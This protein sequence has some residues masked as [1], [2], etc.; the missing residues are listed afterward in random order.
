MCLFVL[1][2]SQGSGDAA[3]AATDAAAPG[4]EHEGGHAGPVM[5]VLLALVIMLAGAK[6]AGY[7]FQ[8]LHQP[9]VLGEL[10]FGVLIGNLALFGFHG[11]DF[12]MTNQGILILAEIGVILLLFE[13]GLDSNLDEMRSVGGSSLFVAVLGVVAPFFLGWGLS[14][15]FLPDLD[16]MVHIFIGAT[17][18]ATSVGITARVLAD[19]RK[20]DTQEARII[21]GA[22]VLDD[23]LGLVVLAIVQGMILASSTGES[24]HALSIVFIVF[25]AIAF[26][27][28][29]VIIGGKVPDV[30][31]RIATRLNMQGILLPFSLG[32]CFLLSYL[33]SLLDLA[34][35]VGAFAAGLILD[36][37]RF[38]DKLNPVDNPDDL[39]HD[40]TLED[41][42]LPINSFLV[43]VFFVLMGTRVDLSTFGQVEV[44]GFALALS[45][46]AVVGKMICGLGVFG[47]DVWIDRLSVAIGM[48]PRG[49]VGLIFAS[50]GASLMLRGEPVINQTTLSAVVIMVIL[51]TLMTPP[52]LKLSVA[53]A[54]RIRTKQAS[55]EA[56]EASKS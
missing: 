37:V 1:P 14:A 22:A 38:Q 11:L 42:L 49:E 55:Q 33:A 4:G 34:P 48:V 51:T 35:I 27:A 24:L 16:R 53:R 36:P 30:F 15:L 43:P 25:K 9:S 12:L 20:V 44:L 31:A 21:L 56:P 52:L 7:L 40:G 45:V 10:V 3:F 29:A 5:P 39:H 18:C 26:L 6:V 2:W 47:G 23:I 19:L 17:L 32:F 8:K 41:L 28:G 46:T 13:V 50:V 54:D